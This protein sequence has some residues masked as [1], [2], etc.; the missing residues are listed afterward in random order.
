MDYLN[1]SMTLGQRAEFT[2][3]ALR[4]REGLDD[5]LEAEYADEGLWVGE[6]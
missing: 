4:L 3:V 2:R 6:E 5:F 1:E